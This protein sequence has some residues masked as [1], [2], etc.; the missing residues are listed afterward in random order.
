M[1]SVIKLIVLSFSQVTVIALIIISV[2]EAH[3][4]VALLFFAFAASFTISSLVGEEQG[5]FVGCGS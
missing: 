2:L 4:P 5:Y 3:S 1:R